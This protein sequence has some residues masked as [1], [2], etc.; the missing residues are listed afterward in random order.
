[1]N[2]EINP[3]RT[4]RNPRRADAMEWN[5]EQRG[6]LRDREPG[7][8]EAFF[9]AFFDPLYQYV[10]RMVGHVQ[11]A[12]DLTQDVF[13]QIHRALDRYDPARALKPW[14]YTIAT[15]RVRDH[16]RSRA[17]H[18]GSREEALEDDSGRDRFGDDRPGPARE[19][20]GKE[21][22]SAVRAAVESL[23]E[24][25]RTT[26]VL[27]F[28][29]GLGFAEIAELVDRNEAAVRKRYSRAMEELRRSLAHLDPTGAGFVLGEEA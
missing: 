1:M 12:E 2:P 27:R 23:P 11:Q 17:A 10:W 8:M 21:M 7:A 28:H 20:D 29:E 22:G 26:F 9:E 16:W 18:Q 4:R 25:L 5:P 19:L 13:M 14:V 6:A 15:N 24:S 3:A